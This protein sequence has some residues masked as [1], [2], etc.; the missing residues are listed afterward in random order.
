MAMPS[1]QGKSYKKL[2]MSNRCLDSHQ[3]STKIQVKT[4]EGKLWFFEQE[5]PKMIRNLKAWFL[6]W[7]LLGEVKRCGFVRESMSLGMSLRLQKSVTIP[8]VL[9]TSC[10]QLETGSLSHSCR[11]PCLCSTVTDS[12]PL[13]QEVQ[14][15]AFF[16]KFP[17]SKYFITETGKVSKTIG[18]EDM[19][20]VSE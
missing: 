12:N 3:Q 7:W 1:R 11:H 6:R 8:C 10:L 19:S 16:L 15:N 5:S 17:C 18:S 9:S 13:E 4:S 2:E 20:R 14:T